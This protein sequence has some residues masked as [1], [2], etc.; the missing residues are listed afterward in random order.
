MEDKKIS[1]AVNLLYKGA[2]MLSYHCP[3]CKIPLFQEDER[4]F[5]PSCKKDVIIRKEGEV[6]KS[7]SVERVEKKQI[8]F[9]GIELSLKE[10]I[11]K[12]SSELREVR[13]REEMKEIVDLMDRVTQI[14]EKLKKV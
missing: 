11:L 5:C 2:K 13:S 1:D 6:E 4:V 14:L 3:N 12:L 10:T 9:D 7:E 8:D